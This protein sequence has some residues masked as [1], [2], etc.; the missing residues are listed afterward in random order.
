MHFPPP[1]LLRL[2]VPF[3]LGINDVELFSF[4]SVSKGMVG[5]CGRRGGYFECH[6]VDEEIKQQLYK[7]ASISLCPSVQGQV[8]VDLMINPPKKGDESYD[9]YAKEVSDI[10]G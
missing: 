4:H 10:Y 7:L 2:L 8:M 5:E 3:S 1:P 6:N 9:S